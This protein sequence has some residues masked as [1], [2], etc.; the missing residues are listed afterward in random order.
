VSQA[1]DQLVRKIARAMQF[2]LDLHQEEKGDSYKG[3]HQDLLFFGVERNLEDFAV[4]LDS[5]NKR[6]ILAEGIGV[7]N[8]V[9]MIIEN[10]ADDELKALRGW[11]EKLREI[12]DL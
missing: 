4:A 1:S 6:Q 5:D 7:I 12:K 9:A 3:M 10:E 8:H 2:Y 11:R